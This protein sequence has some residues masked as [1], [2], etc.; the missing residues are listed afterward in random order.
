MQRD[1]TNNCVYQIKIII[2]K[3]KIYVSPEIETIIRKHCNE[4]K[5]RKDFLEHYLFVVSNIYIRPYTDKRIEDSDFVAMNMKLLRTLVSEQESKTIMENLVNLGI[6]ETD[7][8]IIIGEKSNGYKIKDKWSFAWKLQEVKD[9]K[10]SEK[11][12]NSK[13]TMKDYVNKH[14][15]GY[16]IAH[17][18]FR[19][20]EI[21]VKKSKKY[22]SNRYTRDQDKNKYNSALCSINLFNHEMKFISV[23]STG[24]RLH[25]NLTNIDAKLRKFLTVNR[26]GLSQVDISNSQPLFLGMAMKRNSTVEADELDKY[27][28]IVCSGLFYKFLAAKMPGKTINLNIPD[29]KK[30]FK[31]SIFSGV[32]FDI[33]RNKLSKYEMLF[34][35]E[36]PTIFAAIRVIKSKDHNAMAI[37]L[38]KMESHFIFNAVA[39][40]DREIGRGKAPLLTIHDSIVST[41]EYIDKVKQIMECLFQK[42]FGQLPSLEVTKFN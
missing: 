7:G 38:Q 17:H 10:L 35:K 40:I 19:L 8:I 28:K 39:V 32:L 31:K 5:K 20:I 9:L 34:Q 24:N 14:G 30:K 26:K 22:I 13:E 27:L 29:V 37:M 23:D 25:C 33:N 16:Q 12:M 15:E 42:E 11:L 4:T 2:K 41:G 21:D 1:T 18:W 36:F 3:L 6:L